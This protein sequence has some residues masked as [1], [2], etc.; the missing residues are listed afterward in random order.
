M[1]ERVQVQKIIYTENTQHVHQ[2]ISPLPSQPL[3]TVFK[4]LLFNSLYRV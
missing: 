2:Y 3:W 4:G 1:D